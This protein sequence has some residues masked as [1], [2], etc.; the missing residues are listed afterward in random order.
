MNSKR[1]RKRK[2][3]NYTMRRVLVATL[4]IGCCSLVALAGMQLV[5]SFLEKKP[6]STSGKNVEDLTDDAASSGSS[7]SSYSDIVVCLDPGH[8]YSDGGTQTPSDAP[9]ALLEKDVALQFTLI[10]REKLLAKGVTVKMTRD[11]QSEPYV[12]GEKAP[13]GRSNLTLDDRVII[14]KEMNSDI[15]FSVHCDSFTDDPSIGGMRLYY[16]KSKN[17][18]NT[19]RKAMAAAVESRVAPLVSEGAIKVQEKEGLDA[20]YVTR[21]TSGTSAL[22]ELGF[23]TN[24]VDAANLASE[25][26]IQKTASAVAEGIFDYAKTLRK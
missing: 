18:D 24:P 26:W 11:E 22:L 19:G 5:N 4:A 3:P 25:E 2:K 10:V 14:S 7:H 15:F 8:G 16:F 1:I 6:A 9:A 12:A 17:E 20:Y 23:L 21:K 13:D